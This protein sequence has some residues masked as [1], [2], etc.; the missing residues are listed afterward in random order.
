MSQFKITLIFKP[1]KPQFFKTHGW[2]YAWGWNKEQSQEN[3]H[4][5]GFD[6]LYGKH[7]EVFR[8][9]PNPLFKEARAFGMALP[10]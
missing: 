9:R 10:E 4:P 8:G 6:T 3:P 5:N 7:K 1:N 2:M